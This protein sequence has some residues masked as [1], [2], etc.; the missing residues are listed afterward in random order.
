MVDN[1]S[2]TSI[3]ERSGMNSNTSNKSIAEKRSGKSVTIA[4]Q[5]MYS[6]QQHKARYCMLSHSVP[7]V[8][9]VKNHPKEIR[10]SI[11]SAYSISCQVLSS[12][13]CLTERKHP[14]S[15]D[16]LTTT[17]EEK[18]VRLCLRNDLLKELMRDDLDDHVNPDMMF[19]ACTVQQTGT[20]GFHRDV[21]NCPSLDKTVAFH[22]PDTIQSQSC[23]SFLYYSRKCVGD[24][25]SRMD[26]I[27]TYVTD[28]NSCQLTVLCLKAVLEVKGIFNYQ[29]SLFEHED[30]LNDLAETYEGNTKHSCADI[31]AFSGLSCFKHGAAFDKMGYYS[32]FVNIFLTFFY[33]K[34]VTNDD[35]AISLCIYF[36]LLCNGT[37]NLAAVL[38]DV[39]D[40]IDFAKDWSAKKKDS[41]RLFRLLLILEKRRRSKDS[42]PGMYGCCKLPRFQ[43]ANYSASVIEEADMVHGYVKDF[44]L[45][46]GTKK[47]KNVNCQ[48]SELYQ[49]L[50]SIK[51]IGPL[52]FNQ[53]WH[54]LCLCGLLPMDC[55]QA[56][57]VAPGSGP[58]KLIQTYYP[59]S[60]SAEALLSKM[61]DV[62]SRIVTWL[63]LLLCRTLGCHLLMVFLSQR[64]Q[65]Q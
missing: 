41:T 14:F 34:L 15:L 52:S 46:K 9:T 18:R 27:T 30:C 4:L 29:G 24:Y 5:T 32:I 64:K 6:H 2:L 11:V 65:C 43:Y 37:S 22:V 20:L 35:D 12:E 51:G 60:K 13:I 47:E 19:E 3:I 38:K 58:A 57:A 53:F 45:R 1:Q 39:Y 10:G 33:L 44:L 26:A 36:G 54:S 8:P 48:H 61:H 40:N 21:M 42:K 49:T 23:L 7:F 17:D 63:L 28:P 56:T 50:A 25:S 55:V 31:S 62:K 59:N 16:S